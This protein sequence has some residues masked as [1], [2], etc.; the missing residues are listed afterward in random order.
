MLEIINVI[1]G[2]FDEYINLKQEYMADD[3]NV[4]LEEISKYSDITIIGNGA[5]L[6]KEL[7][8]EK[9]KNAVIE[10]DNTQ[11]AYSC[12]VIGLKKFKEKKLE[13]ADTILPNYLRKSQAERLKKE[14]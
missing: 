6:H 1:Y 3:I 12:G 2:I 14:Q 7:I 5:E 8:L 13:D 4:L 9:I 11:T 10:H